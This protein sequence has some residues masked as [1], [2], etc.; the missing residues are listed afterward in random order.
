MPERKST[1]STEPRL[2][3]GARILVWFIRVLAIVEVADSLVYL[4]EGGG[5]SAPALLIVLVVAGVVGLGLTWLPRPLALIGIGGILVAIAPAIVYPLSFVLGLCSLAAIGIP[6]VRIV[7]R[8]DRSGETS[9]Q[10]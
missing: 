4:G 10:G 3:R 7:R 9:T 5:F 1:M 8:N 6:V 2:S